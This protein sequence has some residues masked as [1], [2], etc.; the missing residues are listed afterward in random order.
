MRQA[1][2]PVRDLLTRQAGVVTRAQL[3]ACGVS[4]EA[5]RWHAGR[6]WRVLL[7]CTYLLATDTITEHHR[8]VAALLWAGEGAV[9]AGTTAARWHGLGNL[10]GQDGTV[11]I[12]VPA[13]KASRCAGFARVRRTELHD[14]RIVTR[15]P[16]RVSSPARACVDAA[17]SMPRAG[18]RSALLI[19]AVQRR[20]TTL[21]ALAEWVHRLRPRDRGRLGEALD[22]AGSGAWSLPEHEVLQLLAGSS[23]LPAPWPNPRLTTSDGHALVTP[24]LWFDDVALAVMVHSRAYHAHGADWDRTVDRD[25]ELT[26]LGVVVLAVTPAVLR[27]DPEAFR[28]RV[29]AAFATAARRPRPGVVATPRR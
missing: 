8:Q 12:L 1:P 13:P 21:D 27:A 5:V 9:L 3:L 14:A 19:E 26:S 24:D 2:E 15:G 25:A 23:V 22:A 10:P 29:E 17:M 11:R 4:A 18:D 16:V 28:A 6:D 7:P 20:L